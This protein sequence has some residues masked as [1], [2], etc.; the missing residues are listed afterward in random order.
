MD[1]IELSSK[2]YNQYFPTTHQVFNSVMFVEEAVELLKKYAIKNGKELKITFPPDFYGSTIINETINS[3]S[4]SNFILSYIDMNYQ[5]YTKDQK[6]TSN[7][8]LR[9]AV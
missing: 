9:S 3:I 6:G 7:S 2:E 4:R 1:L 5:F 8:E